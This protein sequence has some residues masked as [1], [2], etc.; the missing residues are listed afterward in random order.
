M[1]I[2]RRR[3]D[4]L[5]ILIV[6]DHDDSRELAAQWFRRRGFDVVTA[7]SAREALAV[8][9]IDHGSIDVVLTD[10]MLHGAENGG[11][12]LARACE[13]GIL[14]DI[15]AL[16]VYSALEGVVCSLPPAVGPVRAFLKPTDIKTLHAAILEMLAEHERDR[17]SREAG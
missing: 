16:L 14:D 10:F 3:L 13:R 6:E 11:W 9:E 2:T 1:S 15:G 7:E 8:L 5:R 17:G 4:R 12:L